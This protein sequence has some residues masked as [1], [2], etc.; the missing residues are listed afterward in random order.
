MTI[1]DKIRAMNDEELADLLV[2]AGAASIRALER[3]LGLEGKLLNED[4]EVP[5]LKQ[6]YLD[7]IRTE[8]KEAEAAQTNMREE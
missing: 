3:R 8:Y 1:A 6:M 2:E 7:Y 5:W 4:V